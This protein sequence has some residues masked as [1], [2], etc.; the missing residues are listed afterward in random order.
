MCHYVEK[1]GPECKWLRDKVWNIIVHRFQLL[2]RCSYYTL[3]HQGRF[4]P[5]QLPVQYKSNKTQPVPRHWAF[6]IITCIQ[7]ESLPVLIISLTQSF[8][9]GLPAPLLASRRHDARVNHWLFLFPLV[10]QNQNLTKQLLTWNN[11]IRSCWLLLL[12]NTS[13]Y[14]Y[15]LLWQS[16]IVHLPHLRKWI[17][18]NSFILTRVHSLSSSEIIQSGI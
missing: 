8:V 16:N 4:S 5:T 14:I 13:G 7:V 10:W 12:W 11:N 2:L 3:L 17:L 15:C 9:P 18:R 6:L 1:T